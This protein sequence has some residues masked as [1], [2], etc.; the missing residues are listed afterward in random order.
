MSRK[1]VVGSH[2]HV[3]CQH[4]GDSHLLH[5]RGNIRLAATPFRRVQTFLAQ[6][7]ILLV[8][9]YYGIIGTVAKVV[10]NQA[11]TCWNC[12]FLHH[13]YTKFDFYS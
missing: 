3:T 6:N 11:F 4:Q 12:Y 13:H 7:L 8:E 2:A 9:C 10:V 1:L 5:D